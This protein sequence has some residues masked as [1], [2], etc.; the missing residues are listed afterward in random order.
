MLPG[1]RRLYGSPNISRSKRCGCSPYGVRPNGSADRSH[2]H[3]KIQ[4][5]SF[6]HVALRLLQATLS[7]AK[8]ARGQLVYVSV[9][10]SGSATNDRP[11]ANTKR[12][13]KLVKRPIVL[14]ATPRSRLPCWCLFSPSRTRPHRN[15]H[16]LALDCVG[17]FGAL[18]PVA[19]WSEDR[20]TQRCDLS[21]GQAPRPKPGRRLP[22]AGRVL[23]LRDW[24]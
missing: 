17:T 15:R 8:V 19:A 23:L 22:R 6:I 2:A 5:Q 21:A 12:A 7:V 14:F 9:A 10:A 11:T 3:R 24:P 13:I 4:A 20:A 1:A 18:Q 16:S